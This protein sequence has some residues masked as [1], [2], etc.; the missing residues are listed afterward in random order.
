MIIHAENKEIDKTLRNLIRLLKKNRAWFSSSLFI[1]NTGDFITIKTE[2]PS[3]LGAPI[4]K[5]PVELMVPA[6]PLNLHVK[7]N[8]FY[9]DPDKDNLSEIQIEIAEHM[10]ELYNLTNKVKLYKKSCPWIAY[11]K[12]PEILDEILLSRTEAGKIK[13]KTS[14]LHQETDA[15]TENEFIA[16]DFIQTR[17]LG[18]KKETDEQKFQKIMP[19]VDYLDHDFRANGFMI[20]EPK[21]GGNKKGNISELLSILNSQPFIHKSNC[22]VNYGTYDSVDT[23]LAYGFT[24]NEV[25]FVRSIPLTIPID[26]YKDIEVNSVPSAKYNNKLHKNLDDIKGF[27]PMVSRESDDHNLVCSHLFIGLNLAPNLLRRVLRVLIRA[28]TGPAETPDFVIDQTYKAEKLIIDENI[29]F[30]KNLKSKIQI[31][32]HASSDLKDM[33]IELA[34]TQLNKLYKYQYNADYFVKARNEENIKIQQS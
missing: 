29:E 15:P 6:N 14:F 17:V 25:P 7:K 31:N 24:Y 2:G 11:R 32:T 18:H 34:N 16:E 8:E 13:M 20:N 19:I 26:G 5:L 4:I 9:I 12:A 22:Y 30:Y 10:I 21:A 1:K 33:A 3:E 23:F 27:M 28:L